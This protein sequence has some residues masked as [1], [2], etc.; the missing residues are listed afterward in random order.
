MQAPF[1]PRPDALTIDDAGGGA[2]L[3]LHR[4]SALHIKRVMDSLQRAM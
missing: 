1:F 4:L 3:A 2:G